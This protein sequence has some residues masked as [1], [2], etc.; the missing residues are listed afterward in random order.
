MLCLY[1]F[2]N[3]S[4]LSCSG[5]LCFVLFVCRR[6]CSLA[7]LVVNVCCFVLCCV[8]LFLQFVCFVCVPV[9]M[10]V[11]MFAYLQSCLVVLRD[12]VLC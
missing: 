1:L 12:V 4:G 2:V 6:D 8:V 5:L 7:C 11:C 3:L 9:C 10:I